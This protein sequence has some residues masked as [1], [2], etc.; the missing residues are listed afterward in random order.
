MAA[1]APDSRDPDLRS[2]AAL[3][4][5]A[6]AGPCRTAH[7]AIVTSASAAAA[8]VQRDRTASAAGTRWATT[9]AAVKRRPSATTRAE[10]RIAGIER[11]AIRTAVASAAPPVRSAK[12]QP[13]AYSEGDTA[14]G[15]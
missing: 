10:P 7:H 13:A 8:T 15:E 5:R 2:G 4:A 9:N 11:R 3:G 1:I 14:A 12:K 6:F